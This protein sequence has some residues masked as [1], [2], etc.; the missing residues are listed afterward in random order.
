MLLAYQ[1]SIMLLLSTLKSMTTLT[2]YLVASA[3]KQM[4]LL[5]IHDYI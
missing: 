2:A 5:F 1:V 3:N 4:L